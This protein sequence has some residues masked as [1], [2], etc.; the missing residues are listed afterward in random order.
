M[1]QYLPPMLLNEVQKQQR[2]IET[3]RAQ[4]AELTDRLEKLAAT[5][6]PPAGLSAPPRRRAAP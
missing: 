5:L 2:T 4:I 3:M 1:Y 6:S